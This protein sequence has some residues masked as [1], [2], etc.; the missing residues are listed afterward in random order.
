MANEIRLL[1]EAGAEQIVKGLKKKI[2]NGS[3]EILEMEDQV[4]LLGHQ[5]TDNNSTHRQ[6]SIQV[7][8]DGSVAMGQLNTPVMD[9]GVLLDVRNDTT[10]TMEDSGKFPQMVVVKNSALKVDNDGKVHIR[11]NF[12]DE[13]VPGTSWSTIAI[14]DWFKDIENKINSGSTVEPT[15]NII[16]TNYADLKSMKSSNTLVP[17]Q[18]YKFPYKCVYNP[19]QD[20]SDRKFEFQYNPY[21]DNHISNGV[22][23]VMAVDSHV[24]SEDAIILYQ[25]GDYEDLMGSGRHLV[26]KALPIKYSFNNDLNRF[27]WAHP[28]GYGVI[29]RMIDDLGNDVPYDFF[30]IR[31]ELENFGG[32]IAHTFSRMDSEDGFF[33][34]RNCNRNVIKPL[35]K[36][37]RQYLNDVVLLEGCNDNVIDENCEHIRMCDGSRN[38]VIRRGS[39]NIGFNCGYVS[40]GPGEFPEDRMDRDSV[41]NSLINEGCSNIHIIA[42]Y[43]GPSSTKGRVEVGCHCNDITLNLEVSDDQ[44]KIGDYCQ[45]ID[46]GP[47]IYRTGID[48]GDWCKNISGYSCS[49]HCDRGCDGINVENGDIIC[50]ESCKNL[51]INQGSHTFGNCCEDIIID[52]GNGNIFG[53]YCSN[54]SIN[55]PSDEDKDSDAN[56]FGNYCKNI[57]VTG[58]LNV[59]GEGCNN[60]KVSSGN[61]A[62][63]GVVGDNNNFGNYCGNQ[64]NVSK[65]W[66]I[67]GDGNVFGPNCYN[68]GLTYSGNS[69]NAGSSYAFRASYCEVMHNTF[70]TTIV[71]K[72]NS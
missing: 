7:S 18:M 60:G 71:I 25:T 64:S 44:F 68:V 67:Y 59:F 5:R 63:I 31:F 27:A 42:H 20:S 47:R 58:S 65:R 39:K 30:N 22:I 69:A 57:M 49:I 41:Y 56:I 2:S 6:T 12:S 72:K 70:E 28:D 50:G 33:Y 34:S 24:F 45:R 37:G 11:N 3:I 13:S 52:S 4:N 61:G 16:N 21:Q 8:P 23:V 17:G 54:I 55:K 14:Q 43:S 40:E 36:N 10:L 66:T 46:I 62:T 1:D 32:E 53:N 48:I 15:P 26:Q 38:N 19:N 51:A 35:Y 29:Y 9:I